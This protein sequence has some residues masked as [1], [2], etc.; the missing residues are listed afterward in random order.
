MISCQ[1][2]NNEVVKGK[3]DELWHKMVKICMYLCIFYRGWEMFC[4]LFQNEK[5]KELWQKIQWDLHLNFSLFFFLCTCFVF[6]V[7]YLNSTYHIFLVYSFSS[8]MCYIYAPTSLTAVCTL[9]Y[10]LLSTNPIY[11][12]CAYTI[13]IFYLACND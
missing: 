2:L 9:Q 11:I 3:Y 12:F 1:L 13:K 8:K 4:G 6:N 7:R 5:K 10:V